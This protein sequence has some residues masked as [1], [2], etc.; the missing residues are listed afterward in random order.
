MRTVTVESPIS[1]W[2]LEACRK[3]GEHP[4]DDHQMHRLLEENYALRT[5]KMISPPQA[6]SLPEL[7]RQAIIP[8]VPWTKAI[9]TEP[10]PETAP[11]AGGVKGQAGPAG[12]AGQRGSLWYTGSGAPTSFPGQLPNDQYLDGVS[13]D[14]YSFESAARARA[15][16]SS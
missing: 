16:K 14:V 13:G 11:A 7:T 10:I 9:V 3:Y 4:G 1:W 2:D 8:L 12:P 6:F 15:A 5:L